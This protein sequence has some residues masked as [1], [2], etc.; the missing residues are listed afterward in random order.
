MVEIIKVHKNNWSD[1][2]YKMILDFVAVN[3]FSYEKIHE[4]LHWRNLNAIQNKISRMLVHPEKF[5]C[6]FRDAI[7]IL[8][9]K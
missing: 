4:I 8:K 5:D 3:E 7:E 1:R 6:K 9:E 2:E